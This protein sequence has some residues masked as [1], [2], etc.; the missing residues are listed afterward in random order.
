M[1]ESP[2][3]PKFTPQ[4][5]DIEDTM[6]LHADPL[7]IY[8]HALYFDIRFGRKFCSYK[9][10]KIS[11]SP[12]LFESAFIMA[13]DPYKPHKFSDYD[14]ANGAAPDN[15]KQI[16]TRIKKAFEAAGFKDKLFK[17]ERGVEGYQIDLNVIPKHLIV[18]CE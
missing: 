6:W 9:N 3:I 10:K 13:S 4:K 14:N 16:I 2:Y 8:E 15:D 18:I 11:L 5:F 7:W 17:K 12:K 1:F